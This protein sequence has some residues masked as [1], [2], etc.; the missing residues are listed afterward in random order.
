LKRVS[1]EMDRCEVIKVKAESVTNERE[2]G[3]GKGEKEKK[4][5]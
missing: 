1:K 4:Y 3:G 5:A 2:K